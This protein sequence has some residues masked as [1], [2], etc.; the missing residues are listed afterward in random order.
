MERL[1]VVRK[2]EQPVPVGPALIGEVVDR[3][4]DRRERP[5]EGDDGRRVP[6]VEVEHVGLLDGGERG[7]R[8]R[9]GEEA[10]VVVRPAGPVLLV[11]RMWPGAAVRTDEGER[12]DPGHR[13][14]AGH[15]RT[16]PLGHV[17]G[18]RLLL[19]ERDVA[20]VRQGHGDVDP[21]VAQRSHEPCSR[22]RQTPDGRHGR[23][24]ARGEED[25][26]GPAVLP[27]GRRLGHQVDPSL[28]R[29]DDHATGG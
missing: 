8:G 10:A 4:H 27:A 3:E 1:T 13:P 24:L 2:G 25:V 7:D 28:P 21:L 18:E 5:A 14:A 9:E 29:A 19:D 16:G 23:Q 15:R 17:E 11:V 20:V 22:D 26:H 12:P 6:V